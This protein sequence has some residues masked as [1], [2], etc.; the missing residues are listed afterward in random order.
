MLRAED[1]M[2]VRELL[3]KG[4]SKTQITEKLRL[5]RKTV[6]RMLVKTPTLPETKQPSKLD[7]F[8]DYIVHR[9]A[10][11]A[12]SES[13]C[14]RFGNKAANAGSP[15]I[16]PLRPPKPSKFTMLPVPAI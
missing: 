9:V 11:D 14:G 5:D 10:L 4:L 6:A 15:C 3:E 13:S 2:K 7:P 1:V 12:V 8:K 16:H